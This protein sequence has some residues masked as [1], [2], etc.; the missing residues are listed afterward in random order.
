MNTLAL[1]KMEG[2][3]HCVAF[4]DTWATLDGL[5]STQFGGTVS[6][7]TYDSQDEETN[8]YNVS[9]FPTIMLLKS[10]GTSLKYE[11]NRTTD[12]ILNFVRTN[13]ATQAGG[14][15]D[16]KL[17]YLKYKAKYMKLKSGK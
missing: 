5:I 10:D 14:D 16:Y 17:K 7:K 6:T 12:D 13:V 3:S 8:K 15:K 1:F 2:C 11:G 4:R 9:G